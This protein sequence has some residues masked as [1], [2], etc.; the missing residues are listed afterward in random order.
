MRDKLLSRN[1]FLEMIETVLETDRKSLLEIGVL[2][3]VEV[4]NGLGQIQRRD[5]AR[6]IHEILLQILKEEDNEDW[7]SAFS[8]R[9]IYDCRTCLRHIAQVYAKGIM[10]TN[11][12]DYFDLEGYVTGQEAAIYIDRMLKRNIRVI[13]KKQVKSSKACSREDIIHAINSGEKV[14]IIDV[15]DEAAFDEEIIIQGSKNI[16]LKKIKQNPYII[17]QDKN[18]PIYLVCRHGYQSALAAKLLSE[19]GYAKVYYLG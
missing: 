8:L 6:I 5:L 9:D 4:L 13:P 7:S 12:K 10:D 11:G 2:E 16:P 14:Q 19:Y 18:Q 15:R 1:D 3:S 17:T